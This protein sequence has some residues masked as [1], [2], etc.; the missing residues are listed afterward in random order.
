MK[1][2]SIIVTRYNEPNK[3]INPCLI[4]LSK[5]KGI[6]AKVYFLDQK[7]DDETKS[8]CKRLSNKNIKIICKNIP[9]KSLSYARN[10]GIKLSKTDIILFTDADAIPSQNWAFE[11]TKTFNS[12][13]N[14]V[15]VGGRATAKW[16]TNLKWY[17]KSNILIDVYSTL[18]LGKEVKETDRI[19]GVNFGLNKKLLKTEAFFDE[20]QG[21]R[22]NSLLSGEDCDLCK[23]TRGKGFKIFYNGNAIVQHQIQK[24]RMGLFWI[25]KRFYYG[26]YGRAILGGM[27][28]TY[29]DKRNV[30]DRLLIL[31]ISVPYIIGFLKGKITKQK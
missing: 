16:L 7:E 15:I 18:D 3:L 27:P 13:E 8:L 14:I 21:R 31:I 5:Q 29:T 11:L 30:Y 4:A 1:K 17:H 20:S 28:K 19:V 22:P 9:A 24:E 23:R 12:K 6:Q 25:M 2:V 26:G 10:I